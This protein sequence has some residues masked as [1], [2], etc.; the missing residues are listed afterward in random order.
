M[1]KNGC[2]KRGGGRDKEKKLAS[3]EFTQRT[4][5]FFSLRL[6]IFL[7][8]GKNYKH[9]HLLLLQYNRMLIR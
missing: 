1:V 2:E 7:N 8:I 3:N 9:M 5:A 4:Y 6:A